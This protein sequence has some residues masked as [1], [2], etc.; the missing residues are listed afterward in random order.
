MGT[1]EKIKESVARLLR[2]EEN[3]FMD[4]VGVGYRTVNYHLKKFEDLDFS[5]KS[6]EGGYLLNFK[7]SFYT[8]AQLFEIFAE[9]D[10]KKGYYDFAPGSVN[11]KTLT[12]RISTYNKEKRVKLLGVKSLK[13]AEG[14]TIRV[15]SAFNLV[16]KSTPAFSDLHERLLYAARVVYLLKKDQEFVT[17]QPNE[18]K[19]V[20]DQVAEFNRKVTEKGIKGRTIYVKKWAPG[21]VFKGV[22]LTCEAFQ[23]GFP[24]ELGGELGGELEGDWEGELEGGSEGGLDLIV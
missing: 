9:V 11:Y 8:I 5:L 18:F 21:D 20:A 7:K 16:H 22:S 17:C 13:G 15:F 19:N 1:F 12:T 23:D 3:V 4:L 10:K 24:L 14:T 6:T 2:G